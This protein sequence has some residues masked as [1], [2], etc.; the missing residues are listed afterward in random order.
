LYASPRYLKQH[1]NPSSPADLPRHAG[2]ML[3]TSGGE[4]QAW[5]LSRGSERWE[6]VPLHT[7]SANSMGL[8]RALSAQGLG[9]VGLSERFAQALVDQGQLQRILPDWALPPATVWC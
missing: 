7:L 1:G 9:I 8:Q 3:V 4:Q 6:G 5:K 2:L